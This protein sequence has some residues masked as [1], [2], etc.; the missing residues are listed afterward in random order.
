MDNKYKKKIIFFLHLHKCGGTTINS[1]F[2]NYNKHK[3]NINGNPWLKDERII[4]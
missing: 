1:L 3:P 2:K 4:D